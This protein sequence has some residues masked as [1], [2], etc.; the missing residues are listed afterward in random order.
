MSK[1]DREWLETVVSSGTA[2]DKASAFLL[3][4][5]EAPLYGGEWLRRLLELAKSKS[6]H[7]SLLAVNSLV[8]AFKLVLPPPALKR[9]L[10][11]L[12]QRKWAAYREVSDKTLLVCQWEDAVKR[13]YF[14]FLKVVEIMLADQ[15]AHSRGTA[16]R[17]LG[18]L[19]ASKEEQATNVLTMLVN[20]L[21]DPDRR[22]ASRVVYYLQEVVREQPELTEA[23]VGLVEALVLRPGNGEKAQYYGATFLS[24][25]MLARE[26]AAVPG[27]LVAVY[28]ALLKRFVIPA[29]AASEKA[30]KTAKGKQ[31]MKGKGR[32]PSARLGKATDEDL[33]PKTTRLAK[34][35]A[36]GL[37]RALPYYQGPQALL[38]ELAE[39]IQALLRSPSFGTILQ[40]LNLYHLVASA[41][42][43]RGLTDAFVAT[44]E[45][46]LG[47][48]QVLRES[49]SHPQLVACL[50]RILTE[51]SLPGAFV[52][53]IVKAAVGLAFRIASPAFA[54]AVLLLVNEILR[55]KP[56]LRTMLSLPADAAE[57]GTSLHSLAGGQLWELHPMGQH[58]D[59]T[60][61][62]TAR[63]ICGGAAPETVAT[64]VPQSPFQALS[65]AAF[66][67][68]LATLKLA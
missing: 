43:G 42:S 64:A 36:I 33:D 60:V 22:L 4:L 23:I 17:I 47:R 67:A 11:Y 50:Y 48:P 58:Y 2:S 66:L 63:M 34:V 51:D 3:Q 20:K 16:L 56:A 35:V 46:V 44:V 6:R 9:R 12:K 65:P 68:S 39:P 40:A 45:G 1:S 29:L 52:E 19:A 7:E 37:N 25:L 8:E 28:V 10:L 62:K 49:S 41:A 21:G 13:A 32:K 38:D 54:M 5:Q 31:A 57:G 18:Q 27:R 55:V 14:E 61:A 53:R 15:I 24:Q 59:P 26:H 30:E